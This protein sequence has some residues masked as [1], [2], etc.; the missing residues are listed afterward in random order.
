[1]LL[2]PGACVTLPAARNV[3]LPYARTATAGVP[4]Q[5]PSPYPGLPRSPQARTAGDESRALCLYLVLG[6]LEIEA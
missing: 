6:Y 5:T 1:L 2:R 4:H 3:F